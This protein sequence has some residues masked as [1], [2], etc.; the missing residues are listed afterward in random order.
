M[1]KETKIPEIPYLDPSHKFE[2]PPKEGG[3][4]FY[5]FAK[6]RIKYLTKEEFIK[7]DRDTG[8]FPDEEHI[9]PAFHII[10][11]ESLQEGDNLEKWVDR[12]EIAVNIDTFKIKG[13]DYSDLMPFVAEH[14][15]YE[16]WLRAKKGTAST[17]DREKQHILAQRRA[18]LL[19]EQQGLGD[20]LLEW[21]KLILP[22]NTKH[23]EQCEYALR[24][25]KR[26]LGRLKIKK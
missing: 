20:R 1:E 15:I 3:K 21:S 19:A 13:K 2:G 8:G 16:A 23:I 9:S 18:F 22:D 6:H 10:D 4:S 14:E 11:P 26:Q 7:F 24:A 5:E 17:F 25:A 12:L